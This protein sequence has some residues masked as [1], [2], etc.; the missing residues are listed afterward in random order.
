MT[1]EETAKWM[2]YDSVADMNAEH[3]N[4]HAKICNF[5]EIPS[6]ALKVAKG[7]N[8]TYEEYCIANYE[9]DAVLMLQRFIQQYNNYRSN[10]TVDGLP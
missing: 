6:Y 7:E 5:L 4:L 10:L 1:Q 8:L 9:E 2:G 3:D